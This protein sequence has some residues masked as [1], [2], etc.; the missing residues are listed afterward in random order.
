MD[1][2]IAA[3]CQMGMSL[4][5]HIIFACIGI[6]LPFLMVLA[7]ILWLRTKDEA[8][9]VLAKRWAHGSAILFAVGAVSGT[10]L[11]FELGLLWPNFMHFAGAIIGLPF[12]LEG[13]AFFAE[14]IF[15]GIYLYGWKRVNPVMHAISGVIVAFNGALSAVF[16]VIAN[17]WMNTPTGFRIG[18]D[19]KPTNIDPIG[20]ML[21]PAAAF[22]VVHMLIGAYLATAALMAGIHGFIL[23]KNRTSAFHKRALLISAVTAA[24]MALAQPIAGDSIARMV[25]LSQPIKLASLEGQFHTEQSAPLR[26]GGIPDVQTQKV[27]FAIEIPGGLSFLAFHDFN[28]KVLGLD[29]VPRT[30]WPPVPAVH[31]CFQFMVMSGGALAAVGLWTFFLLFRKK[32]LEDNPTYLKAI[33]LTAP[34]GFIGVET[35]W[36]VTEL[37]RQP[38]IIHGVMRVTKAVTPVPGIAIQMWIFFFVYVFLMFVVVWIMTRQIG[39]TTSAVGLKEL[40]AEDDGV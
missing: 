35:G 23:L 39:Q 11:S 9:L 27:N 31:I 15:L 10:I 26:I 38:Y 8:Y 3:R 2:L 5:F 30:D 24:I 4:A 14:A 36:M 20:A 25:A 6:A 13:Y 17:A 12:A 33:V 28:H 37:G 32:K 40:K 19:G 22:E 29:T 1:N 7:E 21:N 16:V 34:L 18:A